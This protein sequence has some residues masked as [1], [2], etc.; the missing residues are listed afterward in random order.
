MPGDADSATILMVDD[1]PTT[2]PVLFRTL[3]DTGHRLLA[4][5]SGEEALATALKTSPALILLDIMMPPGID[6]FETI[7]RLKREAA[8]D[9]RARVQDQASL[10]LQ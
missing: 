6:G 4:A 1:N 7:G 9:G 10:D 2:L 5:R 3:R 8:Q